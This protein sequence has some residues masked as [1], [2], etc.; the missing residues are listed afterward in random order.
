LPASQS[1]SGAEWFQ[2]NGISEALGYP[3]RGR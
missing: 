2:N 3:Y 1:I